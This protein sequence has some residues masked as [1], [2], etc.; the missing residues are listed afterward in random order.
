[1]SEF[2]FDIARVV[3]NDNNMQNE[4]GFLEGPQPQP[5]SSQDQ[6]LACEPARFSGSILNLVIP[7]DGNV[8]GAEDN[9]MVTWIGSPIQANKDAIDPPPH[10]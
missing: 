5:A 8:T 10:D 4:D 7:P 1:M 6:I 9:D 2:Q 3:L